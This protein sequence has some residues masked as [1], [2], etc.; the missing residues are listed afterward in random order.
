MRLYAYE[1]LRR[2][3]LGTWAYQ[4]LKPIHQCAPSCSRSDR[5]YQPTDELEKM[6]QQHNLLAAI[7]GVKICKPVYKNVYQNRYTG[8]LEWS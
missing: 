3:G 1:H 5:Y 4:N 8:N 6:I 7:K 2:I